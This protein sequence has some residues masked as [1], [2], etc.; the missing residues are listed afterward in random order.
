MARIR[1][2]KPEFAS[3]EGNIEMSDSCALFYILLWNFVDD[4]GKIK[5]SPRQI[6]LFLCRWNPDKV[7]LFI[8][9]LIKHQRL[10]L[11]LCSA[12]LQVVNWHH[13]KID[14]PHQPKIK[15]AELQWDNAPSPGECSSNN[16]RT[17][18]ARSGEDQERKERSG[19]EGESSPTTAPDSLTLERKMG[20][21]ISELSGNSRIE[22]A[23]KSV[24]LTVQTDWVTRWE[25]KSVKDTLL[26]GINH[27]TTNPSPQP[28]GNLLEAW[29]TREKK[30]LVVRAKSPTEKT[31]DPPVPWPTGSKEKLYGER[32]A[33]EVM[34]QLV[35]SGATTGPCLPSQASQVENLN[36]HSALKGE[37]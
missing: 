35:A 36:H 7:K 12:W 22:E 34:T 8:G 17:F 2:I 37:S 15:A 24:P 14:R 1:S 10:R 25:T 9:Y 20:A 19:V 6:S 31:K 32:S 3:D 28:M 18:A 33:L 21:V 23:V 16:R 13:Q 4:E 26:N 11:S 27:Y 30:T 29:V 5:N